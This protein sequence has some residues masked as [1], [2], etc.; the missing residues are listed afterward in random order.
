MTRVL[1]LTLLLTLLVAAG[2]GADALA[3]CP[4][5]KRSTAV[6]HAFRQWQPCPATGQRTGACPGWVVDHVQPLCLTGPSGDRI[7]NLQWQ[8][9]AQAAKKDVLE[10]AQCHALWGRR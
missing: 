3:A 5:V 9:R 1:L 7:A 2:A 6:R 10:R 4:P 8:T